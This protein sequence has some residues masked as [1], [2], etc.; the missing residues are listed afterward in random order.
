MWKNV[1]TVKFFSVGSNIIHASWKLKHNLLDAMAEPWVV[2]RAIKDSF[3]SLQLFESRAR[4]VTFENEWE[5]FNILQ[6]LFFHL[7]FNSLLF[8]K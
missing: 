4:F 3:P 1:K 6:N 7:I 8:L 5:S 2:G